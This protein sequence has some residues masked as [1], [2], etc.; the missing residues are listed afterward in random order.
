MTFD[1]FGPDEAGRG[2]AYSAMLANISDVIAVL[3][4]TDSEVI[5]RFKSANVR[6]IFGWDPAELEGRATFENVHPDDRPGM[7][8][9]LAGLLETPDSVTSGECRYLHA[10]G[11]YRWIRFTAANKLADPVL[12]GILLNYRDITQE[13]Q[14][15]ER[16][17]STFEMAPMGMILAD[18]SNT[19][20]EANRAAERLLGYGPGELTGMNGRDLIHP[21]DLDRD[22]IEDVTGRILQGIEPL[23]IENRFRT[24]SGEYIDV[25]VRGG[26]IDLEDQSVTHIVQFYD[27]TRRKQA[28]QRVRTLLQEKELLLREMHHRIKNDLSLVQS[29][30]S[31][32]ARTVDESA[33]DALRAAGY[34]VGVMAR[35][36]ERLRGLGELGKVRIADVVEGLV[37]ELRA[38][39][40][41]AD[42]VVH[43]TVN[44]LTLPARLAVSLGIIINELITNAVKYAFSGGTKEISV[45]LRGAGHD[46]IHL[47]VHD[48]GVGFPVEVLSGERLGYGLTIAEALVDQHQG[49]MEMSNSDGGHV[50]ISIPAA[51]L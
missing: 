18:N 9:V 16:F 14:V 44:P 33:A 1:R 3:S 40:V 23:E 4:V 28:E 50:A 46:G 41:P 42:V 5:N 21:E 30:L 36:Y 13:R 49:T 15:R 35:V 19:I 11:R 22:P 48:T 6:D 47:V 7:R 51:D 12:Q 31:T 26:R 2:Q 25:S 37:E 34:R 17:R 24:R 43:T 20:V 8:R 10:D 39:L 45:N 29:L 32:Q 27:I 38:G